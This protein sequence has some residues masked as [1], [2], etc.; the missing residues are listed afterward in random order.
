MVPVHDW[1]SF[2]CYNYADFLRRQREKRIRKKI[3]KMLHNS[4]ILS[5][6]IAFLRNAFALYIALY[7]NMFVSLNIQ[8][9]LK[10]RNT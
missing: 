10:M 4:N 9:E 8:H 1:F 7:H 3:Q 5:L 2:P 6:V